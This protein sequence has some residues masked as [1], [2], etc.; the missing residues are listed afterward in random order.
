LLAQ[1]DLACERSLLRVIAQQIAQEQGGT[2]DIAPGLLEQAQELR[3]G[4][5]AAQKGHWRRTVSTA[6]AAFPRAFT[7]WLQAVHREVTG[8]TPVRRIVPRD[9]RERRGGGSAR[10]GVG[11]P[12]AGALGS[13]ARTS[14][15]A[16]GPR[17][18]A[19][20][21]ARASRGAHR[22][23]GGALRDGLGDALAGS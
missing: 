17:A 21:G 11:D 19:A 18:G 14:A 23:A 13:R 4:P 10:R 15:V 7:T 3:V 8:R 2:L 5:G 6:A 9:A 16:L 20:G 1:Q 22:P 12:A